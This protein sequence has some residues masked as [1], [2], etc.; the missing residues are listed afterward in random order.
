MIVMATKMR[1]SAAVRPQPRQGAVG[2]TT[3]STTEPNTGANRLVE[4]SDRTRRASQTRRTA[5]VFQALMLLAL[6]LAAIAIVRY[7]PAA[8]DGKV[9]PTSPDAP[10]PAVLI[11][12]DN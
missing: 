4:S 5:L 2:Q 12:P 10:P 7:S 6:V 1:T 8:D 11:Q 9:S 3:L